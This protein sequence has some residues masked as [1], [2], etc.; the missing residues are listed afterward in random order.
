MAKHDFK[1]LII[2]KH[3][4][5]QDINRR[6]LTKREADNVIEGLESVGYEVELIKLKRV[7]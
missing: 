3:P 7:Y 2:A 5:F 4:I 6:C 1:Y